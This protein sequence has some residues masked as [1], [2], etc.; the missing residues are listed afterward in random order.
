M[1]KDNEKKSYCCRV[2]GSAVLRRTYLKTSTETKSGGKSYC[3][4]Y[5]SALTHDSH[6]KNRLQMQRGEN[7]F[8]CQ[9]CGSVFS[10]ISKLS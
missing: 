5:G 8:S 10:Q 2:C 1:E 4:E 9:V 6:L 3:Q 7:P